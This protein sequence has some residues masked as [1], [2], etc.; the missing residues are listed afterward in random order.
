MSCTPPK[1]RSYDDN[2]NGCYIP[3]WND[4]LPAGKCGFRS[5]KAVFCKALKEPK[6]KTAK[7]GKHA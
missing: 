4:S 1:Y 5:I 2:I 3:E 6:R 7:K